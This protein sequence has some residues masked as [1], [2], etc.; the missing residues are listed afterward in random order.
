[1]K[2]LK[3]GREIRAQGKCKRIIVIDSETGMY[4]YCSTGAR[5]G[6]TIAHLRYHLCSN[7]CQACLIQFM[8]TMV[9]KKWEERS[10]RKR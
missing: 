7:D 6:R 5:S 9:T 10:L 8:E 4:K 2:L 1:M 3:Y